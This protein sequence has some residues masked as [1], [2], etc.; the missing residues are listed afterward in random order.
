MPEDSAVRTQEDVSIE[1][2][3]PVQRPKIAQKQS[4]AVPILLFCILVVLSIGLFEEW[5]T[6]TAAVT[7]P[8]PYQ[9]VLLSNGGVFYGKLEGYGTPHPVLMQVYYVV[10]NTN[11]ETK[12]T[13]NVLVK[14]GKELHSPDRMYLNPNQIVFVETVGTGSRVAQ[15]ISQAQ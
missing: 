1:H 12:Q 2:R 14:R 7:F 10:T 13:S 11:A 8:T 4:R 3:M 6:R 15:L 9:A 5:R